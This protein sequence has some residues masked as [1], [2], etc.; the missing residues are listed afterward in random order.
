MKYHA[1][2]QVFEDKHI[3]VKLRLKMFDAAITSTVLY[4]LE[5]CP[6]TEKKLH[7]LDVVQRT[8]LR[9]IIGWVSFGGESWEERRHK[10]KVRFKKCMGIYPAGEWSEAIHIR[11]SILVN[12]I[13]E[14]PFLTVRALK[15]DP[16]ACSSANF[17][18]A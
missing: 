6:L 3:P 12:E 4:S 14:L 16:I 11:K 17:C 2:Q 9:R 1:L 13:D 10:M 7:R 8:M 18:Y 5:T 15:W